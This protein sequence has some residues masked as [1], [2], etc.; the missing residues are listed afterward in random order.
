LPEKLRTRW[1][2]FKVGDQVQDT[3]YRDAGRG[4][5]TYKGRVR[6]RHLMHIHF[7]GTWGTVVYDRPHATRFLE[8]MPKVKRG[9]RK[10]R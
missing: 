5:I 7:P 1:D 10:A 9:S 8:I 2:D 3:W 6:S 4:E